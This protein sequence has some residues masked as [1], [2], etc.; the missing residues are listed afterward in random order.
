MGNEETKSLVPVPEVEA[1]LIFDPSVDKSLVGYGA[2]K[3][4]RESLRNQLREGYKCFD[5]I[6]I[7]TG[8]EPK[9][10]KSESNVLAVVNVLFDG[11]Y[12]RKTIAQKA[13][14]S[15]SQAGFVLNALRAFGFV[16]IIKIRRTFYYKICVNE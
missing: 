5:Y 14:L 12:S 1:E 4:L 3:I 7:E 9:L 10:T 6:A 15:E 16:E 13:H 2:R 8:N 11:I